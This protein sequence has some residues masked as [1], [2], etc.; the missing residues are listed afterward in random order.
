MSKKS[1]T[2]EQ[3]IRELPGIDRRAM[4]LLR[5]AVLQNEPLTLEEAYQRAFDEHEAKP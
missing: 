3:Q 5:Q 4:E 1:E 2:R